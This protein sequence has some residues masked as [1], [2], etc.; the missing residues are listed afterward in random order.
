MRDDAV[1]LVSEV[2]G[3][4]VRH[5][6]SGLPGEM[7]TMAVIAWDSVARVEVTDRS[8]P[9]VPESRPTGRYRAAGGSGWLWVWRRGGGGGGGAVGR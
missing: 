7:I 2:F 3:N 4:S 9:G 6:D 5:T 8:G 1:L